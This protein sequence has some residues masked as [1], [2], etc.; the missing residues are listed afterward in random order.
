[1]PTYIDC[2]YLNIWRDCNESDNTTKHNAIDDSSKPRPIFNGRWILAPYY[3]FY[4]IVY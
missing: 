2:L 4:A 3:D 1:M